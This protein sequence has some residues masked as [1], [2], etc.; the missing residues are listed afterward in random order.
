MSGS[1]RLNMTWGMHTGLSEIL[2]HNEQYTPLLRAYMYTKIQTRGH[3]LLL[4]MTKFAFS[5]FTT[6]S[7]R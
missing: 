2:I 4:Q 3:P 1:C 7:L 5:D 6:Q